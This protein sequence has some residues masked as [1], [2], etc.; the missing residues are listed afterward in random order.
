MVFRLDGKSKPAEFFHNMPTVQNLDAEKVIEILE[1]LC[2]EGNNDQKLNI[3]AE[4]FF[5]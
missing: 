1:E 5:A 3:Q 4:G 2:K